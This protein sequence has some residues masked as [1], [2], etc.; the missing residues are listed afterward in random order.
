MLVVLRLNHRTQRDKRVST[1]L[2]LAARAFGADKVI[3][4]GEKDDVL[5]NSIRKI[6]ENWGGSFEIEYKKNWLSFIKT[7]EGGIVHLT[8][9]GIPL[10]KAINQVDPSKDI[11]VIVGGKKVKGEVYGLAGFNISV[12]SQP[13]S[14]VSSLALFL[15]ELFEGKEL[16]K[17]FSNAKNV[18]LPQKTGK[19]V[20]RLN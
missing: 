4:S 13:H 2:C 9:Y 5:E 3:Y 15:H 6:V 10:Q 12:S 20:I 11:L 1:H 7:W 8:M 18:I 16:S 19:K 14:E 17:S